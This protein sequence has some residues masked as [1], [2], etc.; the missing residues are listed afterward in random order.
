[1]A[2]GANT[3]GYIPNIRLGYV[4]ADMEQKQ[5][6][7]KIAGSLLF[8]FFVKNDGDKCRVA[9][10]LKGMGCDWGENST[11]KATW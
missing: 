11:A 6:N 2:T 10:V 7:Q 4:M 1:M 9:R 3:P 5:P 8:P